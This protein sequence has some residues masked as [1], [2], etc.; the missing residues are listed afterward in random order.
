MQRLRVLSALLM[1]G[2]LVT[3]PA[4]AARHHRMTN[5]AAMS[6]NTNPS[7]NADLASADALLQNSSP[8]LNNMQSD[9]NLANL[10]H[11]AKGILIFPNFVQASAGGA[12]SGGVFMEN[13]NGRWSNP[14]FVRTAGGSAAAQP[15]SGGSTI[16]LLIMSDRA[17]NH[18]RSGS[19]WSLS[20]SAKLNVV[21]YSPNAS[22][23]AQGMAQPSQ[24]RASD[25]VVWTGSNAANA[26]S[27]VSIT[28]I[29]AN[30]AFD[31]AV[32]G[33]PNARTIIAGR[34]PLTNQL[35]VN[36]SNG[37]PAGPMRAG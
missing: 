32:Y 16:A 19:N 8:V 23:P 18:L 28:N 25:V 12:A 10:M 26:G 22:P 17:M 6:Q 3:S 27:P 20:P 31:R 7:T 5:G 13:N 30:T 21:N 36:L 24:P 37:L 9:Q 33:T 35:A 2:A 11:S 29:S 1:A 34:A 15:A 4:M 14:V